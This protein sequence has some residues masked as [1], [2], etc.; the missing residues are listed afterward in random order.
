MVDLLFAII[1]H[2]SLAF[3]RL[4]HY[5]KILVDVGVFQ[6]GVEG[7]H[8]DSKFRIEENVAYQLLLVS[9]N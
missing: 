9:D 5:E 3:I 4:G 7:D 1:E 2:F 6:T 8:F